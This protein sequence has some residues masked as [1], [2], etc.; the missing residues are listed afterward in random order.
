M[1]GQRPIA[2]SM[3]EG[4]H[5]GMVFCDSILETMGNTPLVR[6][7]KMAPRARGLLL[8]KVESFNPGGSVKDRIAIHI[9]QRAEEAGVLRPGGTVVESTSGNTGLGLAIASA[10]KG[11]K[12]IFTMPDKMSRE[13]IN[14]LKAVGARVVI[15]PTA[16]EPDSPE[17]YYS[18]ARRLAKEIPGAF[19]ANQYHNQDN[20]EAHYI[21]TGPEIWEAT[22]GKITHYVASMGTGGTIS[23]TARYLK[24]KN[25]NV[26]VIGADPVG[27]ILREYWRTGQMTEAQPY[28]VE[29]IGEDIIP[30]T[31][32]FQYI[33]DVYTIT[34]RESFHYARALSRREGILSG[35]SC[36]TAVAAAVKLIEQLDENAVVVV[37]LPD[38][39]ERYLG[40]VHSDEWLS[41]NGML[42]PAEVLVGDVL[43][44]KR[45]SV[46]SLVTI[47]HDGTV[48]GALDLIRVH[49][50]SQIPVVNGDRRVH[51]TVLESTL[52]KS[53][54]DGKV[55]PDDPVSTIMDPPLPRVASDDPVTQALQIMADRRSALLVEDDGGRLAGIV[56][57]FDL[58]GFAAH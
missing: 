55:S 14:L 43:R 52:M 23:G 57:H 45:A 48:R 7:Q 58:I 54:L 20:P 49:N 35:G 34:D 53:L 33:D 10:V 11:Y 22:A 2:G 12:C 44:M 50:I 26:K 42:D 36:G 13:K 4:R 37:I 21:T 38:T 17:S 40:K 28:L 8:A 41:D 6:L 51:G 16:V 24:E 9:I 18:V 39:G 15:C 3:H 25:A 56:S 19:L 1:T 29:G 31:T 46:P 5:A 30:T 47:P 32:H 27:S